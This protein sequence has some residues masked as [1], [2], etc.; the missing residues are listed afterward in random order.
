MPSWARYV[1]QTVRM[2][3]IVLISRMGAWYLDERPSVAAAAIVGLTIVMLQETFR[4]LIVN[5]AIVDGLVGRRWL[6]MIIDA[7][8]NAAASF[9]NGAAGLLIARYL[10]VDRRRPTMIVTAAVLAAAAIGLF[11][12]LPALKEAAGATERSLGVTQPPELYQIP[13]GLYMYSF[14]YPTFVEPTLA[15]FFLAYLLLPA[16]SGAAG[17]RLSIF[18]ALLLL[19]RGRVIATG[20]YSFWI[21]Q[22]KLLAFAAEGQFFVE[23]FVMALLAGTAWMIATRETTPRGA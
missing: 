23:T 17:R 3:A 12:L 2:S 4:V 13:F 16:L 10:W 22:P 1:G 6:F 14:I 5:I 15:T 20:L 18:V 7:L 19:V 9:F 8:P 21:R 11:L